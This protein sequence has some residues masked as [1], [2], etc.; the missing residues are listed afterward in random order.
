MIE[1][2]YTSIKSIWKRKQY[3]RAV[4][5]RCTGLEWSDNFNNLLSICRVPGPTFSILCTSPHL[6]LS[7]FQV[8]ALFL[9][10]IL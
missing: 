2:V 3:L 10:P 5:V 9:I 6:V 4:R 8:Q 7:A 1:V